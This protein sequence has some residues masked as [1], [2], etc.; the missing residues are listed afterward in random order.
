MY[1]LLNQTYSLQADFLVVYRSKCT[2]QKNLVVLSILFSPDIFSHFGVACCCYIIYIYYIFTSTLCSQMDIWM[3]TTLLV[4]SQTIWDCVGM[5][6]PHGKSSDQVS[7]IHIT[8]PLHTHLRSLE[9]NTFLIF[10]KL[11]HFYLAFPLRVSGW[12]TGFPPLFYLH[13]AFR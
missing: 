10:K 11:L 8:V 1:C 6:Q 5:K 7:K 13:N 4:C 3:G 2:K 9:L 12:C